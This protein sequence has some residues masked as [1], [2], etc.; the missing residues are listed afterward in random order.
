MRKNNIAKPPLYRRK[1]F[2]WTIGVFVTLV[3]IVGVAF[4]V[5]PWP[6]ALLIRVVFN[7]NGHQTLA[8]MEKKLPDYPVTVLSD[9]RYRT[10]DKDALLDVYIPHSVTRT[11][12]KLPVIVWTHGGAW[13]SGDKAD[14][15]PYFKRLADQGFVVIS[16]NY[17]LGPEK[18]Y[19]TAV[20]QLNDAYTYIQTHADAYHV[21][22]NKFVLAG[23]SAGAQLSSQMAAIITSPQ[24]AKEV[25]VS[26][27]L[28]SSRLAG[29]VLF[30]GIYKMEGLT[31]P[32]P[33]LP[34]IIGWGDDVSVWAYT[35][36]R[37]KTDPVIHQM[38]AYYHVTQNFPTTFISG[39]N[40]DPLTDS[41]S[42]PL[43]DKL[44]S[45]SVDV[46][47]LFYPANHQ[48]NL[49]H[50]YQFTFNSD[51]EKAFAATVDFLKAKTQ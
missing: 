23:D 11:R 15:A 7:H 19:P 25:G 27:S 51:G 10:G 18:T 16:L 14:D 30:C 17:S 2:L 46:T 48:P 13:V 3:L 21:D 8:A 28:D 40:A 31:Q 6:G 43:A 49:P 42:K 32:N 38:S 34:K 29:V 50:E 44:T 4:R 5:S 39:G 45:L 12:Q 36:K 22:Q 24:Y 35:G 37:R 9:Q 20:R 26:P 41:Q 47:T 33:T 1:A